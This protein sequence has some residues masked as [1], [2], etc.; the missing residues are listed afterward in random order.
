M[1]S[2]AAQQALVTW[3]AVDAA[4][5]PIIGQRA[6]TALHKRSLQ[7]AGAAHP[8]LSVVLEADAMP[9]DHSA[10]RLMLS[11]LPDA[12]AQ[13]AEMAL[14]QAFQDLLTRLLGVP[15]S[16]QLLPFL[17]WTGPAEAGVSSPPLHSGTAAQDSTP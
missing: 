17:S 9:G 14:V 4:L 2:P 1:T 15:L 5:V 6:A 12:A 13:A 7:V 16:Q 3:L 8:G 10:L 11:Q